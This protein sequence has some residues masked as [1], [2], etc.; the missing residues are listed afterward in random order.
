MKK[1]YRL[2]IFIITDIICINVAYVL[3]FLLR[4]EFDLE[5]KVFQGFF[6]VYESNLLLITFFSCLGIAIFKGYSIYLK[7]MQVEDLTRIILGLT[8]GSILSSLLMKAKGELIPGSVY[9]IAFFVALALICVVRITQKAFLVLGKEAVKS[10]YEIRQKENIQPRVMVVGTGREG[11]GLILE[12]N[13]NRLLD[14]HVVVA[15]DDDTSK[16]GLSFC[17]VKVAG[18]TNRIKQLVRRY[19]VDEI[20][21]VI[22]DMTDERRAEIA[23]ECGKTGCKTV[24]LSGLE[25]LI[26]SKNRCRIAHPDVNK[27]LNR[28]PIKSDQRLQ[29]SYI[30][31]KIILIVGAAGVIGKKLAQEIIRLNPRKLL[32][33]DINNKALEELPNFINAHESKVEIEVILCNASREKE[34]QEIFEKYK[35]HVVYYAAAV[36]DSNIV[37]I[38]ARQSLLVNVKS[39]ESMMALSHKNSVERFIMLSDIRSF[40][41]RDSVHKTE[42]IAQLTAQ[43]YSLIS[44]TKFSVVCFGHVLDP[45]SG[46]LG[47]IMRQIENGKEVFCP[48]GDMMAHFITIDDAVKLIID[49]GRI[50][51]GGEI[52]CLNMSAAINLKELTENIIRVTGLIPYA[53]V[54]IKFVDDSYYNETIKDISF[55]AEYLSET[56]NPGIYRYDYIQESKELMRLFKSESGDRQ[57]EEFVDKLLEEGEEAIQTWLDKALEK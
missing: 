51:D 20:F 40:G 55:N 35:P 39:V 5:S 48:A 49:T 52:F 1:Y 56:S 21:I 37:K 29:A 46:F 44:D 38:N 33:M 34:A 25:D 9:A 6:H 22:P 42:R 54:D 36:T 43:E 30:E 3:A 57:F 27:L 16:H 7:Y 23:E 13:R 26:Y 8:S 17:G 12:I 15:V 31:G 45:G 14:K 10:I 2:V 50:A 32:L 47:D 41:Y 18:G 24:I 28:S 53:D 11:A 4:Y 19:R